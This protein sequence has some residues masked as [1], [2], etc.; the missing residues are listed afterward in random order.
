MVAAASWLLAYLAPSRLVQH[1]SQTSPLMHTTASAWGI[2][3]HIAAMLVKC[4]GARPLLLVLLL[5]LLL[6]MRSWRGLT[7]S[8]FCE[9]RWW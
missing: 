4:R 1:S 8:S 5:L 2:S 3:V 9:M 6:G 7:I